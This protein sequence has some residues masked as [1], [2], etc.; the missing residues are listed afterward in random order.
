MPCEDFA[1]K[2]DCLARCLRLRWCNRVEH[3][4][5]AARHRHFGTENIKR[6]WQAGLDGCLF[7][8]GREFRGPVGNRDVVQRCRLTVAAHR[9]I[10]MDL[11]KTR[12]H[13]G[14]DHRGGFCQRIFGLFPAPG[15]GAEMIA[16]KDH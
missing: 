13:I 3:M 9:C 10:K 2:L 7:G 12:R 1:V 6:F 15:I 5:G 16:A 11:A 4:I 14:L 8:D